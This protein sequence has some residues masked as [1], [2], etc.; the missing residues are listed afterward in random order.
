MWFPVT[1]SPYGVKL[2]LKRNKTAPFRLRFT[3]SEMLLAGHIG[4][5]GHLR[6]EFASSFNSSAFSLET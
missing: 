5:A 2:G 6:C 3:V 4:G 1:F